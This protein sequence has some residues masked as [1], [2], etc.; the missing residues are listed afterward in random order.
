MNVRVLDV[1]VAFVAGLCV[2][3]ALALLLDE[4]ERTEREKLA[5]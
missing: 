5:T 3:L 2:G 1:V 4:V